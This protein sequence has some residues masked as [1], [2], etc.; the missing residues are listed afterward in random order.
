MQFETQNT[1][2]RT[3]KQRHPLLVV[4]VLYGNTRYSSVIDFFTLY[5]VIAT[6]YI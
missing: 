1:V 5:F 4:L 3:Q 2:A 6:I